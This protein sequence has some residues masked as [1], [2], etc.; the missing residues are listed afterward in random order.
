MLQLDDWSTIKTHGIVEDILVVVNQWEYPIDFMV[1]KVNT[2]MADY[3]N[4][5]DHLWLAIIDAYI[6]CRIGN[7]TISN[8]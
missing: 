1:V 7:M 6:K 8:V 3:P 2:N 5:L 4:I